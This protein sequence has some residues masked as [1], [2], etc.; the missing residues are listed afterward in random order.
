MIGSFLNL[1]FFNY[2]LTT[3]NL[4]IHRTT[5]NK[6]NIQ[7]TNRNKNAIIKYYLKEIIIVQYMFFFSFYTF[8]F[9]Q[10]N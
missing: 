6:Q 10:K 9:S 3:V 1:L 2:R 4:I 5:T 8:P 7:N